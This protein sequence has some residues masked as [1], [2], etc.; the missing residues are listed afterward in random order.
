MLHCR[1]GRG[2]GYSVQRF[3]CIDSGSFGPQVNK[4]AETYGKAFRCMRVGKQ[5]TIIVISK[6][7]RIKNCNL[8]SAF[9]DECLLLT[10][11]KGNIGT[12]LRR[13]C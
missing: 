9:F 11:L 3:W 6:L 10:Y 1:G 7:G 2:G 13:F 12:A 4:V 5:G 8:K